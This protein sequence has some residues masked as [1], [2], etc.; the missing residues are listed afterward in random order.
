MMIHYHRN[1]NFEIVHTKCVSE[2][3]QCHYLSNSVSDLLLQLT[4]DTTHTKRGKTNN[5]NCIS[6]NNA[7]PEQKKMRVQYLYY[8]DTEPTDTHT[9]RLITTG[10]I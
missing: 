5:E 8:A 9:V 3:F 7:Y 2:A 6:N 4:D 1:S 10:F